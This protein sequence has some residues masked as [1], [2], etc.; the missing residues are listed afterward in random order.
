MKS[1]IKNS[2]IERLEL[3]T[4]LSKKSAGI[5]KAGLKNS[6]KI[7][8]KGPTDLVTDIDK[9]S[10][11]LIKEGINRAFPLDSIISE[12]SANDENNLSEYCWVIDPLDGTTN[13]VHNYPP[14]GISIGLLHKQIP[15]MGVVLE[16]PSENLYTAVKGLG[17]Y[18]NKNKLNVSKISSLI[19]SLLVTGFGYVKNKNWERNIK[20][21]KQ[22][23]LLTQGV[24][25]SG[26]ASIDL[27]YLASGKV[28]A[29]WEY[30]LSPWD[31]SAGMV[32]AKEAGARIT[33][34]NGDISSIYDNNLLAS[35]GVIHDGMI[36]V[37][38]KN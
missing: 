1:K 22:F 10:E 26:A 31:I 17:A 14:F 7:A 18:C 37:F 32:I 9:N 25:R 15:V 33:Q 3:A 28:D 21:F 38:K 2:I 29:Y 8:K 35:N 20:Y 36:E 13:F 4:K 23:T 34:L 19:N 27:C 12:E 24:R 5:I 11:R 16:L 6:Y 30:D